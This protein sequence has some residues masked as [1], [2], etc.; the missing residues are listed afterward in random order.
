MTT[1]SGWNFIDSQIFMNQTQVSL[2]QD[3]NGP[4]L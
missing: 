3:L 1:K 2:T 4:V